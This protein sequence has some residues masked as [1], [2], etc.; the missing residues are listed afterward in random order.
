MTAIKKLFSAALT[1]ITLMTIPVSA[2]DGESGVILS[3]T[4]VKQTELAVSWRSDKQYSPSLRLYAGDGRELLAVIAAEGHEAGLDSSG[5]MLYTAKLPELKY[6][7][8]YCYTIDGG[9]EYSFTI[10]DENSAGA[11]AFFGDIQPDYGREK[12]VYSAWGGLME[13]AARLYPKLELAVLG[14]DMVSS[15]VSLEQFDL[16]REAA[17]A[18]CSELPLIAVCGNQESSFISGKPELFSRAFVLPENGPEGFADEFYSVDCGGIH[19]IALNGWALSGEQKLGDR[20]V[21]RL[22]AW[23]CSELYD[24]ADKLCVAVTHIP[25]YP[26]YPDETAYRVRDEWSKILECGGTDLVLEGHQHIYSRSEPIL[27]GQRNADGLVYIMNN[28]GEKSFSSSDESLA[29]RAVYGKA[30][31]LVVEE[32]SDGLRITAIDGQGGVFDKADINGRRASFTRKMLMYALWEKAGCPEA[33]GNGKFLD[34]SSE[35]VRWGLENGIVYGF[36]DGNFYPDEQLKPEHE[37]LML[38]RYE[39]LMGE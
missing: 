32:S 18:V 15:A 7:E 6:G 25:A 34:E 11:F 36:G 10:P 35:A 37:A 4:G 16:L 30:L 28:S 1:A 17:G 31:C 3:Q 38:E 22:N 12:D 21:E 8:S 9:S 19:I 23:L 39:R 2:L 27:D 24:N 29:A 26:V 5:G 20:D 13:T 33:K 14:G